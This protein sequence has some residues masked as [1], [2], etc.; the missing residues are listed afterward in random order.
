M[1]VVPEP[2]EEQALYIARDNLNAANRFVAAAER[3]FQLL[4]GMPAMGSRRRLD[5]PKLSG[6]R[7]WPVPGFEKHLIFYRPIEGGIE[8]MRVLH[9]SRDLATILE[10]RPGSPTRLM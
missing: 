5:S 8:V 10:G 6:L 9:A 4:A 2:F 3:A 7:M 1:A